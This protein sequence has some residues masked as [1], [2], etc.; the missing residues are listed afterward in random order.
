MK[1]LLAAALVVLGLGA[2]SG[3]AAAAQTGL[4]FVSNEKSHEVVVLDGD[5][6]EIVKRIETSRRPRDMHFNA[7]K[8]LLYV[9]CGDDDVIDVID[10]ATLEVVDNI[11]TGPSPEVFAFSPDESQMFVSN[12]EDSRL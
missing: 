5:T 11:P 2:S 6:Y 12:E 1:R 7:D 8:T 10:V 9:A 4:V 3:V